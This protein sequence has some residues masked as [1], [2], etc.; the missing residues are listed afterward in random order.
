MRDHAR[1]L[2]AELAAQGTPVL[3]ALARSQPRAGPRG[4]AEVRA[5]AGALRRALDHE[6]PDAI[7]LH[8]ASFAYAQRGVPLLLGPTLAAVRAAGPPVIAF[9]HELAYPWRRGARG[10]FWAASQRAALLAAPK[11]ERRRDRDHRPAPGVAALAALASAASAR[12]GTRVLEP[13]TP[14]SSGDTS[15][16]CA[17]DCSATPTKE[18]RRRWCWT[19]WPSFAAAGSQSRSSCSARPGPG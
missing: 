10:D 13:A 16:R 14:E 12:G 15:I 7:V 3:A 11:D 1:L 9:V 2:T 5:W 4:E 6:R 8:Y 18:P 17:S 19:H